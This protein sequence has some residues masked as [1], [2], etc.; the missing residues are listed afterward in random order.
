M[1]SRSGQ[2]TITHAHVPTRVHPVRFEF[3]ALITKRVLNCSG[4]LA[5]SKAL[6]GSIIQFIFSTH[7]QSYWK[8]EA[9]G[10]A[11][12]ASSMGRL[13]H[14]TAPKEKIAAVLTTKTQVGTTAFNA[15]ALVTHTQP[16]S[17]VKGIYI[18]FR[19]VNFAMTHLE[20][21]CKLC[22]MVYFTVVSTGAFINGVSWLHFIVHNGNCACPTVS[23]HHACC[24]AAL[25]TTEK[26]SGSREYPNSACS[27]NETERM[28]VQTEISTRGIGKVDASKGHSAPEQ[29]TSSA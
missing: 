27:E 24:S 22:F 8:P 3:G 25:L 20:V 17:A 9:F 21:I 15:F 28:E 11:N 13:Q 1:R 26:T 19:L 5:G 10:V 14:K 23:D 16:G 4:L 7:V 12:F 2:S 18:Y 29:V 6:R